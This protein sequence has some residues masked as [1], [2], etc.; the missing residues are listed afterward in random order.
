MDCD[1]I[2]NGATADGIRINLLCDVIIY[3][4]IYVQRL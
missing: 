3:E 1:S 2:Y 4:R